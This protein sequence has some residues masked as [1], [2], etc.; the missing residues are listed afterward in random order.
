MDEV[1]AVIHTK[2]SGEGWAMWSH[3]PPNPPEL[4]VRYRHFK[5][6]E[7]EEVTWILDDADGHRIPCPDHPQGRWASAVDVV[8]AIER[9]RDQ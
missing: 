3:C 1:S 4:L 9:L 5:D 2:R 8:M 7:T 6:P